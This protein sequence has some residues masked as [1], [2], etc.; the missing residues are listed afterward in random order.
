MNIRSLHPK[1]RFSKRAGNYIKYRPGYPDG[2]IA[3][4]EEKGILQKNSIIAD[5]GSGTGKLSGLF[6]QHGYEVCAVEPNREM[7]SAAEKLFKGN[8]RFISRDGSAEAVP[9]GDRSVDLIVVG[10]AFHW[11][12]AKKAA[13]E[14]KR[15]LKK[16]GSIV[17]IWNNRDLSG[18][19]FMN[20]YEELLRCY[21]KDYKQIRSINYGTR[22]LKTLFDGRDAGLVVFDFEQNF[23]F[24]GLKGRL[25][26]TSYCPLPG[27]PQHKMIME[28]LRGLFKQHAQHNNIKVTYK[29]EMYIFRL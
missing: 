11:F 17:L 20:D 18:S 24:T 9:F 14:F 16:G 23:D 5:I 7:R 1:E 12:E 15:I 29:T 25:E 3:C 26:S 28:K 10:Q 4:L 19:G 22:E 8:K 21:G 27:T 2:V 13:R 6:L